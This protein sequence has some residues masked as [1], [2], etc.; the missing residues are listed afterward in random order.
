[1]GQP[2]D[3]Y[4]VDIGFARSTGSQATFIVAATDEIRAHILTS[5]KRNTADH[6]HY[7]RYYTSELVDLVAVRERAIIERFGYIFEQIASPI[8]HPV[9]TNFPYNTSPALPRNS[10]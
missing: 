2:S 6:V 8:S 3:H 7:S 5:E 4:A 10:H 1:M 9:A